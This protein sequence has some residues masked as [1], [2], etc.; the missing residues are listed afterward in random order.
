[1][2]TMAQLVHLAPLTAA[3]DEEMVGVVVLEA[4]ALWLAK[5]E[6]AERQAEAE[7]VEAEPTLG[8]GQVA[9]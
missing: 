9:A 8:H 1:M 6:T 3:T 7:V 2:V 4:K 5:A